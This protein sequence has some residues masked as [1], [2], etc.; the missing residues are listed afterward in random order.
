MHTQP[1]C[2]PPAWP[3]EVEAG[4]AGPVIT[5]AAGARVPLPQFQDAC[6]A[7]AEELRREAMDRAFRSLW[8]H[9]RLLLGAAVSA[10]RAARHRIPAQQ[11]FARGRGKGA[12]AG[13]AS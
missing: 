4:T 3:L 6:R 8:R 12:S 10:G 11:A 7:R 9:L 5:D 13:M 2:P 1:T